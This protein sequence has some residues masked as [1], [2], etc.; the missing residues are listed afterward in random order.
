VYLIDWILLECIVRACA[1]SHIR[2][3]PN[4]YWVC[5]WLQE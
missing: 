4:E 5:K 2:C 1:K 3:L